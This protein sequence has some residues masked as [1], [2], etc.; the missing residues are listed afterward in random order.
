MEELE[1]RNWNGYSV[2]EDGYIVSP[3]GNVISGCKNGRGY[4]I[5]TVRYGDVKM[6][7]G[8]HAIVC[9]AFHGPRPSDSHEAAHID[10]NSYNNHKDN[11]K[12]MTRTQNRLQMY[13]DGRSAVGANNANSKYPLETIRGICE[14]LA[15]GVR[16]KDI[17]EKFKVPKR[18]V[19]VI[20]TRKQWTSVSKNYDF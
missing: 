3:K 15:E 11:L 9:E 7:K 6:T 14:M 10:G 2:R 1:I 17:V 20:K 12:W 13:A 8:I 18:L 19:S 16:N 5:T 4:L